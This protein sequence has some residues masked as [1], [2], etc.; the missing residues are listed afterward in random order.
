MKKIKS[1]VVI[2]MV[3][4]AT[5]LGATACK[6]SCKKDGHCEKASCCKKEKCCDKCSDKCTKEDKCCDK[7][8]VGEEKASCKKPGC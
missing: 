4:V 5:V 1:I 7:C 2:M 3:L 8:T 6:H